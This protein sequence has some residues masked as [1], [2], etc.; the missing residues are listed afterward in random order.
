MDSLSGWEPNPTFRR[1]LFGRRRVPG[2]S[3][4]TPTIAQKGGNN[5]FPGATALGLLQPHMGQN[6]HHAL[7]VQEESSEQTHQL[8]L[9]GNIFFAAR[10]R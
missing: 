3:A 10:S 8:L 2:T 7:F 1:P 9:G 5:L 6:L 4:F